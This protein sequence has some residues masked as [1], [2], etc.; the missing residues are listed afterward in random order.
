MLEIA[1]RAVFEGATY[2]IGHLV[3]WVVTLGR[4]K[5]SSKYDDLAALAGVLVWFAIGAISHFSANGSV[6]R[7]WNFFHTRSR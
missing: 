1:F 4:W 2:A 5:F 7:V 3:L 6:D